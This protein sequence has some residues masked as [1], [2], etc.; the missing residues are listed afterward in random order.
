MPGR[1]DKKAKGAGD[2]PS[3]SRDGGGR[4]GDIASMFGFGLGGGG[5]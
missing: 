2:K 4:G 5:E 3:G 1:K